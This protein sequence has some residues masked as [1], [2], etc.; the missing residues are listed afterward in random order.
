MVPTAGPRSERPS[1]ARL[2]RMVSVTHC[3]LANN[4]TAFRKAPDIAPRVQ[5]IVRMDRACFAVGNITP[6]ARFNTCVAPE[7]AQIVFAFDLPLI[8]IP[9]DVTPKALTPRAWVEEMRRLRTPVGQPVASRTNVSERFDSAKHG[10]DGTPPT[11]PL[12]DRLPFGAVPL[13]RPPHQRPDQDEGR[14]HPRQDH[15]RLAAR[16]GARA[17]RDGHGGVERVGFYQGHR[18]WHFGASKR[19]HTWNAGPSRLGFRSSQT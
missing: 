11:R 7:A 17:Q 2:T 19:E 9:P 16:D 13:Q 14:T 1:A 8:V 10:S 12:R 5:D 18:V 6:A 3:P 4:A 15:R